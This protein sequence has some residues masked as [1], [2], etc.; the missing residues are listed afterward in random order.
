MATREMTDE[1]ARQE[2]AIVHAALNETIQELE[3]QG[4]HSPTIL[5]VSTCRVEE[6]L[7]EAASTH[8][9]WREM[10]PRHIQLG[11]GLMA[12]AVPPAC[13][14]VVQDRGRSFSCLSSRGCPWG[15]RGAWAGTPSLS[16]NARPA[17]A[18]P[19]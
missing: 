7:V 18:F 3:G 15:C 8:Y 5:E 2:I 9:N 10:I 12:G 11:G 4:M 6:T 14:G 17:R 16:D 19:S 1:E 13:A